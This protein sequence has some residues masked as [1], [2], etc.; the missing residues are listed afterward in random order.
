MNDLDDLIRDLQRAG[1]KFK[2]LHSSLP[3]IFGTVAVN[4]TRDNFKRQGFTENGSLNRWEKRVP[5]SPRDEGRSV[6]IDRENLKDSIR[7]WVISSEQVQV[8]VDST[9]VPYAKIQ[10]E[11]GTIKVTPKMKKFFWAQFYQTGDPFWKRMA[12][13]K[14]KEIDIPK[15]QWI[16]MTP[17]LQKAIFRA[18]T[19]RVKQILKD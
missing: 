5:G 11:G 12:L 6:L 17:D 16:G 8:G 1:S 4:F 9:K 3:E 14:K 2:D 15:R 7:K 18:I 19:V 10:N 13:M